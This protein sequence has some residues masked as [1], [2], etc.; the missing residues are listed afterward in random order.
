MDIFGRNAGRFDMARRACSNAGSGRD[1]AQSG[2]VPEWGSGGPGF[3]SRRPD[4]ESSIRQ[5]DSDSGGP[6][7]KLRGPNLF[8]LVLAAAAALT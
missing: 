4:H 7:K 8:P 1:V 6:K 2:S 5:G 3:E